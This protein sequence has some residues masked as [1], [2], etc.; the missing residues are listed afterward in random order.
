MKDLGKNICRGNAEIVS[1]VM[2]RVIPMKITGGRSIEFRKDFLE[3]ILEQSLEEILDGF[4]EKFLK[5]ANN[6]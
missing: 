1:G 5:F 3:Q 6:L 4:A 2:F